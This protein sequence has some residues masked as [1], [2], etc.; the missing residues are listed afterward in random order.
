M[1]VHIRRMDR[2]INQG[3]T[4]EKIYI[5]RERDLLQEI[6]LHHCEVWLGKTEMHR[7]GH[8]EIFWQEL[9]LQ[10]TYR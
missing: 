1:S 4:R 3:S 2:C 7:T 9:T 8:K 6:G 10:F 5:Q